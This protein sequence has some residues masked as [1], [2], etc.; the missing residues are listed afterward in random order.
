MTPIN[1]SKSSK[2]TPTIN[3]DNTSSIENSIRPVATKNKIPEACLSNI[4]N[5]SNQD[6]QFA[7]DT[8]LSIQLESTNTTKARRLLLRMFDN[9]GIK[10]QNI[11]IHKIGKISGYQIRLTATN[12]FS[13][14]FR[15]KQIASFDVNTLDLTFKLGILA[16]LIDNHTPPKLAENMLVMA[17][18]THNNY[19]YAIS[20]AIDNICI[21]FNS[22]DDLINEEFF[23]QFVLSNDN[24]TQSSTFNQIKECFEIT[25][26]QA[27]M[28][29]EIDFS[30]YDLFF[31]IL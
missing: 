19:K 4:G 17:D 18:A 7:K 24:T 15:V 14:N 11:T 10:L 21:S 27:F 2:T 23:K 5:T 13:V 22:I 31:N 30:T 28:D 8:Q 6:I 3:I 9:L 26:K 16:T 1:G 29:N 25:I 12:G 20:L